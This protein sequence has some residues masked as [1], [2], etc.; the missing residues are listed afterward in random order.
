[1]ILEIPLQMEG[2][3]AALKLDGAVPE[4]A[5]IH[6]FAKIMSG[7]L[8]E[9]IVQLEQIHRSRVVWLNEFVPQIFSADGAATALRHT[10]L[11]IRTADCAP[12]LLADTESGIVGALH[13]GWRS[14]ASG[15]IENGITT[16]L[17]SGARAKRIRAVIAPHILW[18]DYPVGEE[19]VSRFDYGVVHRGGQTFLDIAAVIKMRLQRL[20]VE[21]VSFIPLST[22]TESYLPSYR[23]DGNSAGRMVSYIWLE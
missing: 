23:R 17:L 7:N 15:I 6:S 5:N 13:C 22:F 19:V 2:V 18:E 4:S 12:V 9:R 21:Y 16:M 20:G 1:M 11:S 8:P 10:A 14:L 3:K